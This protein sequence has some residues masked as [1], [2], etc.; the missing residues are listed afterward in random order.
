MTAIILM[1]GVYLMNEYING[2]MNESQ[3]IP[4]S[5]IWQHGPPPD[6]TCKGDE[7]GFFYVK[8]DKSTLVQLLFCGVFI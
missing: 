4:T 6:E 3:W 8:S 5:N 7:M 1:S 2:G